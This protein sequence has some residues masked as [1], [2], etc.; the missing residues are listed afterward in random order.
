V[1]A[2]R[3]ELFT[4]QRDFTLAILRE[5][6][7]D[8]DAAARVRAWGE[9]RKTALARWEQLL[10]EL[11]AT[12]NLDF[13]MVTVAARQLKAIIGAVMPSPPVA[14]PPLSVTSLRRTGAAE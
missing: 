10:A 7:S 4:S 8:T 2:L 9:S 6:A 13:A 3:D 1:A 12:T 11:R 14:A 5:S